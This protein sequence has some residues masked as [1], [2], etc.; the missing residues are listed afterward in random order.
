VRE[1]SS[2]RVIE[3][4]AD[5]GTL[6]ARSDDEL[7]VLCK[8]GL[9]EAFATLAAR[10]QA[11]VFGFAAKYLG[12]RVLAEEAFQEVFSRLWKMRSEYQPRGLFGALLGR[13]CLNACREQSRSRR[14]RRAAMSR[15]E[16]A[17][18]PPRESGIGV[19][20][21]L[22]RRERERELEQ[23][24]AAL[25]THL[26]EAVLLRFFHGMR[27]DEMAAALG[28]AEGTLRSRVFKGL[29]LLR[30]LVKEIALP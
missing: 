25:P 10:H 8:A 19:E 13:I 18:E 12:D 20:E 7:M 29:R 28:C 4:A 2:L 17:A 23:L 16:T 3:T 14:R 22:I 9:S 11:R 21:A 24:I 5:P 27:Y 6:A 26:K 15:L 1:V 30:P